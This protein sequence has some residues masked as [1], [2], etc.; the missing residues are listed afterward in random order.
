ME[1][2]YY[3]DK[4]WGAGIGV[5]SEEVRSTLWE[6]TIVEPTIIKDKEY[7]GIK[8]PSVKNGS[9]IIIT[10]NSYGAFGN[11]R[12]DSAKNITDEKNWILPE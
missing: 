8:A 7:V 9:N 11:I 10:Q 4:N 2:K 12:Y 6:C 3:Y 1:D 5:A